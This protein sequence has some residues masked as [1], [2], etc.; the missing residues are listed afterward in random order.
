M[1]VVASQDQF[2]TGSMSS[3]LRVTAV[4]VNS[5]G[6]EV[7]GNCTATVKLVQAPA[8]V[9]SVVTNVTTANNAGKIA[10]STFA[11]L[12]AS[13]CLFRVKCFV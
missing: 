9:V 11:R 6:T 4:P 5:A 3:A 7:A 13:A 1:T 10:Q 8:A 2:E 12:A